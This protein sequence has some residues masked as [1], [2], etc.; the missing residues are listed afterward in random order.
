M[1]LTD[2]AGMAKQ[3]SMLFSF[4][5]WLYHYDTRYTCPDK[6]QHVC[7]YV[8]Y[9]LKCAAF[10]HMQSFKKAAEDKKFVDDNFRNSECAFQEIEYMKKLARRCYCY[11]KPEKIRWL[12]PGVMQVNTKGKNLGHG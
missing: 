2:R 3:Q 5:V 7:V 4:M 11:I 1:A 10:S 6:F 9:A 12:N 8:K